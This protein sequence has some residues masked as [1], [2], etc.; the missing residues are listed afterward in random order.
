MLIILSLLFLQKSHAQEYNWKD[1][2]LIDTMAYTAFSHNPND[3]KS[4]PPSHLFDGNFSTCWVAG[5]EKSHENPRIKIRLPYLPN[6]LNIYPGYGKSKSLFNKN[7]RPGKI[8]LTIHVGINPEGYISENAVMYKSLRY[9]DEHIVN[10]KDTGMIQHVPLKFPLEKVSSFQKEVSAKFKQ[11]LNYP[12]ADTCLILEIEILETRKGSKWDDICISEIHFN[13][14]FV[15][16]NSKDVAN[17]K[18]V[19]LNKEENTLLVSLP[20]QPERKVYSDK[21][22]VLQIVDVSKNKK[23]AV[24]ISMPSNIQGRA[25][26]IYLL[27]DLLNRKIVNKELEKVT[28]TYTS[29]TELFFDYNKEGQLFLKYYDKNFNK[30]MLELK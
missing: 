16:D 21:K 17:I 9:P 22:S 6:I 11:E 26:T 13:D 27:A 23:W 19:F 1:I 24:L 29:G 7:S 14:R 25:E 2:E 8:K 10:L 3:S 5:S 28:G 18:D 4:Y 12:A 15:T 30:R 20:N